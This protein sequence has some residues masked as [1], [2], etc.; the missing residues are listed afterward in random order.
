MHAR[1]RKAM[2][3][4]DNGFTLIELLVVMIIIGIL[5][6]IAIPVFINQQNQAKNTATKSDIGVLGRQIATYYVDNSTSPT[7]A[8]D[9]GKPQDLQ[10]K[11]GTD[12]VMTSRLSAPL[13]ATT[14]YAGFFTS[15]AEWCVS[16]MQPETKAYFKYTAA[17]GLAT[18]NG[19]C[20]SSTG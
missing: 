7:L 12:V 5:A 9:G 14:D 3:R 1:I 11:R 2:A 18:A 10:I 20:T 6:A 4:E 13:T 8:Y 19:H 16:L 15:S 17:T